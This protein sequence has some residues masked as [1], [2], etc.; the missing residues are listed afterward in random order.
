LPDFLR[1]CNSVDFGETQAKKKVHHVELPGWARTPEEF[2]IK[3]REALESDYVSKHLASWIDL[4]FGFKQRGPEAEKA[5]NVFR[6]I[7]YE[8]KNKQF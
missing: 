6:S 4:I 3:H 7:S 1:N 5:I 2:I 8:V